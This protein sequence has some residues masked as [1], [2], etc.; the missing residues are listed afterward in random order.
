[1]N[2]L[3]DAEGIGSVIK[4][5]GTEFASCLE[6]TYS[7][8]SQGVCRFYNTTGKCRFGKH[9]KFSHSAESIETN[10]PVSDNSNDGILSEASKVSPVG[11]V[12]QSYSNNELT[13]K[14][15]SLNYNRQVPPEGALPPEAN[16]C[17]FYIKNRFCRYGKRC[18]YLHIQ[19][20]KTGGRGVRN[21]GNV[22]DSAKTNLEDE[23]E[24]EE[25]QEAQE[26]QNEDL[27]LNEVLNKTVLEVRQNSQQRRICRFFRQGFC[28]YGNRCRYLHSDKKAEDA[29]K[30]LNLA[31]TR[32]KEQKSD[33]PRVIKPTLQTPHIQVY[34]RETV[35]S[36][37]LKELR[38]TEV[39]QLKRRFPKEK[40]EIAEEGDAL[41][42]YIF[43]FSPTDPDWVS[44]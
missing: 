37:K 39:R 43:T 5:L 41:S 12:N 42:R 27:A 8:M 3:T 19:L 40:L 36:E 2:S 32:D 29:T 1:M 13:R 10:L 24:K 9:C 23:K 6:D 38:D 22:E 17:K 34:N 18:R 28:H 26:V 20:P 33:S 21:S 44:F 35:S 25:T 16:L 14:D 15:G 11:V 4:L 31:N 7:V 30:P